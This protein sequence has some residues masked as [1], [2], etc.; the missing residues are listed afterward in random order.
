[1]QTFATD[2]LQRTPEQGD[3]DSLRQEIREITGPVN[4]TNAIIDKVEVERADFGFG[5]LNALTQGNYNNV[6]LSAWLVKK[7]LMQPSDTPLP[8]IQFEGAV[9]YPPTWFAVRD[10]WAQWF[11]DQVLGT[12]FNPSPPH[13]YAL[14][15]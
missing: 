13:R 14:R 7:G 2:V 1:M 5:N 10:T 9:N 11:A 15:R 12:G 3:I 6:G 4:A 8:K